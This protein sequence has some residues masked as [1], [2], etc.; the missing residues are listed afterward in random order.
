MAADVRAP[1][2]R[3]AC[4]ARC[5]A[6]CLRA[7]RRARRPAVKRAAA[8]SPP[9]TSKTSCAPRSRSGSVAITDR[10][11]VGPGP[12][13]GTAAPPGRATSS[14]TARSS[15]SR[16]RR[17]RGRRGRLAREPHG[18]DVVLLFTLAGEAVGD[19]AEIGERPEDALGEAEADREL[20]VVA[21][22]A[23]GDGQRRRLLAG[24]VDADLHR[25]LGHELVR[26]LA[27]LIAVVG[28]HADRG[29]GTARGDGAHAL[30][31]TPG[32][33]SPDSWRRRG[34]RC[35]RTRRAAPRAP[36]RFRPQCRTRPP[37]GGLAT[38]GARR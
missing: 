12:T 10:A 27:H 7:A 36:S 15:R 1:R 20:E 23:H 22:R 19:R 37:R 24:T 32:V 35:R 25:L 14:R 17:V 9:V 8:C 18:D 38:S 4:R 13:A 34:C 21:R 28:A 6:R 11:T 2:G 26:A 31:L 16:R 29:D 5:D 33:R 3:S 30:T